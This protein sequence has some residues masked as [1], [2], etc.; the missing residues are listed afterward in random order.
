VNVDNAYRRFLYVQADDGTAFDRVVAGWLEL[1]E[2][3][4]PGTPKALLGEDFLA[5]LPE[6]TCFREVSY[7]REHQAVEH[8]LPA[9]CRSVG[10]CVARIID[11]KF[12]LHDGRQFD[13]SE[14]RFL[15]PK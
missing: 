5:F 10:E 14:V 7:K 9:W 4:E 6:K 1:A 2:D 11:Q 8:V 13:L 12:V 3:R 15:S